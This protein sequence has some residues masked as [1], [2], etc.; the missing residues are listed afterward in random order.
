MESLSSIQVER[1]CTCG[2]WDVSLGHVEV[3]GMH[4]LQPGTLCMLVLSSRRGNV[5]TDTGLGPFCREQ[6][7]SD[8]RFPRTDHACDLSAALRVAPCL[9]L[10]TSSHM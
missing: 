6:G 7:S 2:G 9:I 4:R 8:C 1:S 5:R 3:Y 10:A